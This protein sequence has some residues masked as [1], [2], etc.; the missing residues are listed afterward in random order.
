MAISDKLVAAALKNLEKLLINKGFN[1]EGMISKFDFNNDGE[2]DLEEFDRGLTELT[3]SS[4]PRSYLQPIFSAIDQNDSGKLSSNELMALLGIENKTMTSSSSSLMVSNHVEEKYNGEYILQSSKMN[5]KDW[6]LNSDNCRL[7]YYDANDGG[8]PSWSFDDRE[9]DG[10]N[11]WYSGGWT[12]VP[13]DGNI[14]LG[15]RRFVGAGKITISVTE[16]DDEPEQ[17]IENVDEEIPEVD[18]GDLVSFAEGWVNGLAAELDQD[19]QHESHIDAKFAEINGKFEEELSNLPVFAQTPARALWK[20]KSDALVSVAKTKLSSDKA[21]IVTGLGLAGAAIGA[22]SSLNQMSNENESIISVEEDVRNAIEEQIEENFTDSNSVEVP[23]SV[24]VPDRVQVSESIS[25]S[26]TVEEVSNENIQDSDDADI[27]LD[28]IIN[29]MNEARFLNEQKELI[30]GFKGTI[31]QLSFK[32]ISIDRTF[33]IGISDDFKRGNTLQV[34]S[35]NHEIEV[36]M[37]NDYD[38]S[39]ISINSEMSLQVS[40]EAWNGIRKRL[41]VNS[42]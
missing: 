9:Q 6:Y 37:K 10:S 2:I 40:V 32:V 42:F 5:G 18:E 36:R 8:A 23:D 31:F 38:T 1:A 7:Y 20:I 30:N 26:L 28:E 11:D 4:A 16:R 41:I 12:R 13:S 22:V 17:N 33:G 27:S 25:E 35:G 39:S 3:G 14:P 34:N 21:K 24:D 19:F 29:L 15:S